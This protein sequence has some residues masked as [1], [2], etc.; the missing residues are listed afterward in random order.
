M[1]FA[2]ATLVV[3]SEKSGISE[4]ISVDSDFDMYRLPGREKIQNVFNAFPPGE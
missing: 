4:I 3:A 2:D 1:D